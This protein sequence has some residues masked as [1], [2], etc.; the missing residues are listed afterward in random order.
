MDGGAAGKLTFAMKVRRPNP[1]YHEGMWVRFALTDGTQFDAMMK[2]DLLT[3]EPWRGFEIQPIRRPHGKG[4][5][6]YCLLHQ[7]VASVQVIGLI[8]CGQRKS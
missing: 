7:F 3:V 1:L 8:G 5:H 2:P 4:I 6:R